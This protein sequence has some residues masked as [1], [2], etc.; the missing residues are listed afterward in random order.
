MVSLEKLIPQPENLKLLILHTPFTLDITALPLCRNLVKLDLS[1]NNL[2]TFP[3]MGQLTSL[4]FIF[5]HENKLDTPHLLTMFEDNP[6]N[7]EPSNLSNSVIWVTYWGNKNE[8]QARHYLATKTK[9]LAVDKNMI[10]EEERSEGI[11]EWGLPPFHPLTDISPIFEEKKKFDKNATEDEY[12][13][14]FWQDLRRIRQKQLLINPIL[15][16]QKVFRGWL[17]RTKQH[18][19]KHDDRTNKE[20]LSNTFQALKSFCRRSKKLNT[21]LRNRDKDYLLL[22]LKEMYLERTL[23]KMIRIAQ[24]AKKKV[25]SRKLSVKSEMRFYG[26]LRAHYIQMRTFYESLYVEESPS[27]LLHFEA[28]G[29]FS[30]YVVPFVEKLNPSK[31]VVVSSNKNVLLRNLYDPHRQMKEAIRLRLVNVKSIAFYYHFLP[32]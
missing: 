6:P 12:M 31:K 5:L 3:H 26:I 24:E 25:F 2:E 29:N 13:E 28:L 4:R 7:K 16:I 27:F 19:K 10:V 23:R 11:Y 8:F 14:D 17:F 1:K 15:R 9:A 22:P 30:T 21:I 20:V 32:K 18:R